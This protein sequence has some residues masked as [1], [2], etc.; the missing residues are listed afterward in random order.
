MPVQ[1]PPFGYNPARP[2]VARAQGPA[3][4]PVARGQIPDEAPRALKMPSPDELGIKLER[5]NKPLDWDQLRDQLDRLGATSFR[6]DKDGDGF[7]FVC[8]LP[9]GS[10]EATGS[11]EAAAVSAAMAKVR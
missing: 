9:S 10:V 1:P 8:V 3:K 5:N 6:L 7:R 11:T 2:P 4:P